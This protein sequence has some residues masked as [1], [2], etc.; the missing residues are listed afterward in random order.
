MELGHASARR[1]VAE[2]A[3]DGGATGGDGVSGD[4]SAWIGGYMAG[5]ARSPTEG[6]PS[7]ECRSFL[8]ELDTLAAARDAADLDFLAMRLIEI[9]L[10]AETSS[11]AELPE[12]TG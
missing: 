5:L 7:S 8:A 3:S 11:A 1:V 12:M 2:T 9:R 6:K 10:D 4:V